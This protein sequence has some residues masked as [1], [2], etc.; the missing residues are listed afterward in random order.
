ML[1]FDVSVSSTNKLK[2]D[3]KITGILL[4]TRPVEFQVDVRRTVV[5]WTILLD[6]LIIVESELVELKT[7]S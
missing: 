2:I 6:R 7:V 4:T 1:A 3:L 5:E